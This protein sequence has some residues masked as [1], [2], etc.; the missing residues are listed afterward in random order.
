M[1]GEE[2][3]DILAEYL[4]PPD[5]TAG[6]PGEARGLVTA[7]SYVAMLDLELEGGNRIALPYSG[8]MKA[9]VNPSTGINL[10]YATATVELRGMGLVPLYKAIARHR[11]LTIK[12]GKNLFPE[13]GHEAT[14]IVT[15][16]RISSNGDGS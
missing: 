14:A 10:T 6:P 1:S 12:A 15:A 9:E 16:I 7:E 4:N 3:D 11:V 13:S 2:R 5:E 8:L